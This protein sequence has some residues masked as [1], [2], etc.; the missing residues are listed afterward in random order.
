MSYE[1]SLD[2]EREAELRARM[3][4]LSMSFIMQDVYE[5][6]VPALVYFSGILSYRKN[7][8]LWREPAN[9]TNILAG[10]LWYMRVLVLEFTLP[11]EQ[12]NEFAKDKELRPMHQ[13]K[14]VRDR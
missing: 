7:T 14:Q 12:R 13:V 9:F 5:V 3:V 11:R 2:M 10:I 1:L 6:G 8:G 4:D